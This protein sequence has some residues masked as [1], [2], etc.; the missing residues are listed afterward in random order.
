[1]SLD[2]GL[3]SR[4]VLPAVCAPM[5]RVSSPALVREACKGGLMGALPRQN[6]RD[7]ETFAAWLGQIGEALKVHA[8]ENP[9][10]RIGPVAV[11][12]SRLPGD[13]MA[14]H[15]AVCR[16]HGVEIIISAMG[17]PTEL[18]RR[19]H[20]WGGKVFHDVTNV[21]FAEKAIAAKADGLTCI[22]SGGGGHSGLISHLAFIPKV[23]A[24]FDGTIIM[25]GGVGTGAAI[26]AAEIL[27][28]DLAY[29]GTRFIATQESNAPEEYKAMLVSSAASDLIFTSKVAGGAANWLKPSLV[30]VGLDPDNLPGTPPGAA[31]PELPEGARPW[32]TI[33]SAGQG[34]ELIDDIPTTSELIR[35]LRSEYVAACQVPD[36]ADVARC[37]VERLIDEADASKPD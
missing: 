19:V 32:V 2:P 6:A 26:R 27:G 14:E 16:K 24:M 3:R 9:D 17:D 36:M 23:R 18:I 7:L 37:D 12:L 11:N 21:R 33:W 22:G 8:G 13:Q 15:L 34:I 20:D 5:F 1:M 30:R 10:A 28:A 4:L 25:A 31:R 29:L 35:R